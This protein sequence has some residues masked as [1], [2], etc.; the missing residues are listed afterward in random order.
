MNNTY[1][2]KHFVKIIFVVLVGIISL[3]IVSIREVPNL[4]LQQYFALK[5]GLG[6]SHVSVHEVLKT[7]P[8]DPLFSTTSES[9]LKTRKLEGNKAK[10]FENFRKFTE[11]QSIL[12]LELHNTTTLSLSTSTSTKQTNQTTTTTKLKNTTFT[13]S[14]T[15][16]TTTVSTTTASLTN[17][18]ETHALQPN[19]KTLEPEL[20]RSKLAVAVLSARKQFSAR[21][22][23]RETWA[24][25]DSNLPQNTKQIVFFVGNACSIPKAYRTKPTK[26]VLKADTKFSPADFSAHKKSTDLIDD[27]IYQERK[28][29]N[30]DTVMLNLADTYANLPRKLKLGYKYLLDNT[31]A[32]WFL[33]S[34]D[35]MFVKYDEILKDVEKIYAK[36]MNTNFMWKNQKS[37]LNKL[38]TDEELKN[39]KNTKI[40]HA[41]KKIPIP[42][43][44]FY[45]GCIKGGAKVQRNG[46]WKEEVYTKSNIYPKFSLGSCGH[47]ISRN[48]AEYIVENDEK[49]F[50]Y[51][52]EDTSLGIWLNEAPVEIKQ[53]LLIQ[54]LPSMGNRLRA[55]GGLM[56]SC[57][58]PSYHVIGHKVTPDVMRKCYVSIKAG[59]FNAEREGNT[60]VVKQNRRSR[61]DIR[62][63]MRSEMK[64]YYSSLAG[65]YR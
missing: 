17:A 24:K 27:K 26:C 28:E 2:E 52:G 51:Q 60:Q 53:Q 55:P 9:Q 64:S 40:I 19:Q 56:R 11:T 6:I 59:Q 65:V 33:K 46:K 16:L 49:L 10:I 38:E 61:R 39:H 43:I 7:E 22:A 8:T 48:L 50:E 47:I 3:F 1:I 54:D 41:G 12:K 25:P 42:K 34:D 31:E 4:T 35:D 14:K 21:T 5:S 15:A 30:N 23:I 37:K 18:S 13:S 45:F 36:Q 57:V 32:Q 20:K 58:N 44:Y 62:R 29:F 63:E